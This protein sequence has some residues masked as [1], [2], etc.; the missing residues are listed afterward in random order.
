MRYRK[1]DLIVEAVRLNDEK[2]VIIEL[3]DGNLF[4]KFPSWLSEAFKTGN[5]YYRY[6]EESDYVYVF[7]KTAR[8]TM[9]A[10]PGD[11]IIKGIDG[12]LYP[13]KADVFEQIYEKV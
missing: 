12:E 1:K 6:P 11:Y 7:I 9:M 10:S 5:V 8:G 3:V 4:D 2:R 13:C